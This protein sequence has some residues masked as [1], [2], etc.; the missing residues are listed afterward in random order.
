[1]P[2]PAPSEQSK[3]LCAS[4]SE[5]DT[6]LHK[7]GNTIQPIVKQ[8][9]PAALLLYKKVSALFMRFSIILSKESFSNLIELPHNL[10]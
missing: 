5:L 1:L 3:R 7:K 2:L 9:L 8:F 6:S 10:F 4:V